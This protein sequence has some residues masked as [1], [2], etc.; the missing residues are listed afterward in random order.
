M[1]LATDQVEALIADLGEQWAKNW[2]SGDLDKVVAPY[3][4]DAV[5][6]PPHHAA[7]HGKNAIREYL[8]GPLL[9]RAI[10]D[11]K[12]E[13]TF[14]KHSGDLAYDVGVFTMTV[15][16]AQGRD[17]QDRGKYLTVWRKQTDGEWKI[18]ADC[19]SSDLPPLM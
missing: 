12:Y 9:K 17:R 7:V 18:V 8:K 5:Y 6:Q 4:D 3:A 19:W 11:L 16:T 1:P 2:N 10:R 13:V 14:V 15:P